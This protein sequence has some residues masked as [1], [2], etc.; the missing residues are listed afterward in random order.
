MGQS[1]L[2]TECYDSFKNVEFPDKSDNQITHICAGTNFG[3]A[4]TEKGSLYGW[5]NDICGLISNDQVNIGQFFSS[6]KKN[7]QLFQQFYSFFDMTISIQT[8]V[9]YPSIAQSTNLHLDPN[10]LVSKP[11]YEISNVLQLTRWFC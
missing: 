6:F 9:T 11:P 1:S 10:S 7:F 4:I 3:L 8:C 5:G 2:F